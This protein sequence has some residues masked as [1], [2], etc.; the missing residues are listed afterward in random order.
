MNLIDGED[1][2]WSTGWNTPKQGAWVPPSIKP[3]ILKMPAR[4]SMS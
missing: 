2:S 3:M 1:N 4:N